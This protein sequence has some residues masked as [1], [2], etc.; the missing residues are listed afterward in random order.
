VAAAAI[1]EAGTTA[2]SAVELTKEVAR[3]TGLPDPARYTT[4]PDRKPR[5]NTAMVR[6]GEPA[7]APLGVMRFNKGGM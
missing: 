6:F 7:A 4:L 1:D 3:A 5:P 2:E